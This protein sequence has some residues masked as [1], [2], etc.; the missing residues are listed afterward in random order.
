[1]SL[2]SLTA[3]L[4]VVLSLSLRYIASLA[5]VSDSRSSRSVFVSALSPPLLYRA[6]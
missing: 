2:T 5:S 6:L 4:V 1:M 3:G